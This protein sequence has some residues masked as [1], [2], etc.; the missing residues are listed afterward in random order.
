MLAWFVLSCDSGF[1]CGVKLG[2][3]WNG[4]GLG[5]EI[6]YITGTV[7]GSVSAV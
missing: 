4:L 6:L 3:E 5:P 2:K 1:A 7:T